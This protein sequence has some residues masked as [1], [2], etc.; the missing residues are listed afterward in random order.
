MILKDLSIAFDLSGKKIE[1]DAA[2]MLWKESLIWNW[3]KFKQG[4][5]RLEFVD[6]AIM[7]RSVL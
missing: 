7:F 3:E 2:L 4:N 5:G 6:L 1:Q